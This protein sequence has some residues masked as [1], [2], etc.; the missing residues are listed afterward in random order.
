MQDFY[1]STSLTP[2]DVAKSVGYIEYASQPSLGKRYPSFLFRYSYGMLD[3]LAPIEMSRCVTFE[4]M[5]ESTPY[6]RL[7]T[8][9]AGNLHPIELYVQIRGIKGVLSGIYHVDPWNKEIV[10][11]EEIDKDGFECF[12]GLKSKFVG[13]LF[14]LSLVP[15]RSAWKYQ[16]RAFRYCYLDL[17]HQIA[18]LDAAAMLKKQKMQHFT[19]KD[20]T[21][22]QKSFGFGK[23]EFVCACIGIG[24]QDTAKKVER[25]SKEL[26]YVSPTNYSALETS[27]RESIKQQAPIKA[28]SY[29]SIEL[30]AS[31][32]LQRRSARRFVEGAVEQ[33]IL[34]EML[35]KLCTPPTGLECYAIVAPMQKLR[36]GLYK[37]GCLLREGDF[38]KQIVSLLVEQ[39]FVQKASLTVFIT[40]KEF[41]PNRLTGAGAFTHH[42]ALYAQKNGLGFSPIGAFYDTRVQAF[43]Q[44]SSYIIYAY[45]VG[46]KEN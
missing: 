28:L 46:V 41:S 26:I 7:N 29:K 13:F 34:I 15:F 12:V 19:I 9:S 10:L 4:T 42:M 24:K 17:G 3:A 25:S 44:T 11:L 31:T 2:L 32:M 16:K 43:L 20:P 35:L 33:K 30:D 8:P 21:L 1:K 6:Q 18:A 36:A 27:I 22:L 40:S 39:N 37:N 5:I 23:D 38:T 14:F 45:V